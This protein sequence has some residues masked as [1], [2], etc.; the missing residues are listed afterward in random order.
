MTKSVD[1][2]PG[3]PFYSS[4][5]IGSSVQPPGDTYPSAWAA[6]GI[7]GIWTTYTGTITVA[8]GD[9]IYVRPQSFSSINSTGDD[10]LIRNFR[11]YYEIVDLDPQA[12]YARD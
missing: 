2:C 3:C 11:V 6:V 4:A 1:A 8:A 7:F 5:V 10:V 12:L 9:V